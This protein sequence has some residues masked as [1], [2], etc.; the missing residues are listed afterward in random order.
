MHH[1]LY[2]EGL[3]CMGCVKSLRESLSQ[4]KGLEIDQLDLSTGRLDFQLSEETDMDQVIEQIPSKYRVLNQSKSKTDQG[5]ADL[6][7]LPTSDMA[8]SKWR[9]LFPL[10]LI[11]G[12]LWSVNG[13]NALVYDLSLRD[14]MLDFMASF[15]L[16][17]SFFKFLDLRG[18]VAA[19]RGYD[20]LANRLAFYGYVYPFIELTLGLMFLTSFAIDLAVYTTLFI[21]GLTTV[22]VIDQL[23]Q[24]NKI[25]CAC[26]GSVL[27]LPMTEA[28]LIE[29]LIMIAMAMILIFGS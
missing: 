11:F 12:F 5:G 2:L 14:F 8:V 1:H 25:V 20:P 15:Y 27:N 18:F 16:V 3:T 13:L 4:V 29:N 21:L 7:D 17:F 10:F 9:Q 19:F 22:G 26:L 24:K 28:T 6:A 23:R